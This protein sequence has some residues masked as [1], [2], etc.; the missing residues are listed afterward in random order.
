MNY[1]G[2]K[3]DLLPLVC[4]AAL[5]KQGKYM[6]GSHIPILKPVDLV[7]YRPDYV[8]ILPW[9]IAKEVV[10]QLTEGLAGDVK[11]ITMIPSFKI[12]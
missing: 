1:A 3:P 9:N 12:L 4:D 2:I 11:F 8:F 10:N 5:S 7:E 6:P